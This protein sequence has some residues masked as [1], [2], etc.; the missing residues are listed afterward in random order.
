[1]SV[2]I[3]RR[4][5]EHRTP[6][7]AEQQKPFYQAVKKYGIQNFE[8][9]ILEEVTDI[10]LLPERE[11]FWVEKIK[12]RYNAT[13]GGLGVS[14]R[15]TQEQKDHLSR[16]AK[17]QWQMKSEEEKKRV[18]ETQLTGPKNKVVITQETRDKIRKTLTGRVMPE[19]QRAKI[20]KANKTR[21][22]GNKNGNKAVECYKDGV[23]IKTYVS[24]RE[25]AKDVGITP[26]N[27]TSVIKGR[28]TT[29]GGYTWKSL[30][31]T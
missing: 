7:R 23:F 11:I 22:I 24:T 4:F 19:D 10:D 20:S 15:L 30:K 6:R 21:M 18:L 8:F 28:Q 14:K 3:K 17:I 25:A 26:S 31:T 12:P 13:K 27:I 29:A 16:I 9:S 2:D 5:M 1:M